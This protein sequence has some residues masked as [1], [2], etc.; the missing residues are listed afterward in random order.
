MAPHFVTTREAVNQFAHRVRERLHTLSSSSAADTA[1]TRVATRQ[2]IS[3]A[4]SR[5]HYRDHIIPLPSLTL[6]RNRTLSLS[7]TNTLSLSPVP[8]RLC[9]PPVPVLNSLLG[10]SPSGSPLQIDLRAP[11]PPDLFA[12]VPYA[13]TATATMPPTAHVRLICPAFPAHWTIELAATATN[14]PGHSLLLSQPLTPATLIAALHTALHTTLVSPSE[15]MAASPTKRARV[16]EACALR[17]A[18]RVAW[19]DWLENRVVFAGLSRNAS[20]LPTVQV[21]DEQTWILLLAPL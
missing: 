12:H 11:L 10:T 2:S 13:T 7:P 18:S 9:Q 1:L 14:I 21:L 6:D 19:I 5:G 15:W 16:A 3:Q 8:S 20:M 17:G 4:H